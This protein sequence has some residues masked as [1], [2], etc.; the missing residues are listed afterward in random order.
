MFSPVERSPAVPIP[1]CSNLM[2]EKARE[3]AVIANGIQITISK[4]IVQKKTCDIIHIFYCY[5]NLKNSIKTSI[6]NQQNKI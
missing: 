6:S 4:F 1:I 5:H 3:V 2:I